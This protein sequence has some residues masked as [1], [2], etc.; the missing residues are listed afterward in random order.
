MI[1]RNNTLYAE[2]PSEAHKTCS[3]ERDNLDNNDFRRCKAAIATM[4]FAMI[5]ITR[6]LTHLQSSYQVII[7]GAGPVGLLTALRLGQE[8]IRTLVLEAHHELLPTTR[9]M[10][11]M[12]VVNRCLQQLGLAEIFDEHAYHNR[13]GVTWRDKN[14]DQLAHLSLPADNNGIFGGSYQLGQARMGELIL[15]KLRNYHSVE[16]KFGMRVGGIEEDENGTVKVMAH[17]AKVPGNEGNDI[18]FKTKY[19]LAADGSNSAVRRLLCIPFDGFTFDKFKMVGADILFDCQEEFGWSS[20]NFIVDPEHWAV[21]AYTGQDG[22]AHECPE[23]KRALW[24]VAFA[25]PSDLPTS[26]EETHKRAHDRVKLYIKGREDYKLVRA[27]LYWLHQRCAA[28]AFKGRVFLA[29]D[30]LHVSYVLHF[31]VPHHKLTRS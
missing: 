28:Q 19:V 9:A 23:D 3:A 5:I 20:L 12:P 24:R 16:V 21:V 22:G 7:A 31:S 13:E 26:R 18:F 6:K 8:N 11:Y 27:E 29:G 30:A 2:T 4:L 25:E 15:E 1:P 14:C 17:E 10:V